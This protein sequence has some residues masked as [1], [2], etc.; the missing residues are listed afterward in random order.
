MIS[1]TTLCLK[2]RSHIL[3]KKNVWIY[4]KSHNEHFHITYNDENDTKRNTKKKS[5]LSQVTLS[6]N[7]IQHYQ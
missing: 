1:N 2:K 5:I 6:R 3:Q 4:N 7:K